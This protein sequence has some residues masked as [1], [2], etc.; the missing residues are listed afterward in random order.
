MRI[1]HV[2]AAGFLTA[3]V[4]FATPPN[5]ASLDG[6]P[7]EYD[8]TDLKGSLAVAG[9]SFGVGNL[10][11]N[12]FV[13]WDSTYLY[14]ALQ[15]YESG[16]K[17]MVLVDVDPGN[18]TGAET[19]TNW[20]TGPTYITFNDAGWST[21]VG[22]TPFGA[23]Y[24]LAS[25][26]FYNSVLRI[27]YTGR[28]I[29]TTGTVER[30]FDV[31]D[32]GNGN[33]PQGT[34]VD[35]VIQSDGSAND[36]KGFEARIPWTNL[37]TAAVTNR[38]GTVNVG[39][40]VPQGATLRFFANLH[41]N[42]A[43]DPYSAS[44]AIPAQTSGNASYLNGRL[45]S[46]NYIDVVVDGDNDGLP[47]VGVGDVNGPYITTAGGPTGKKSAFVQF[48]EPVN[49]DTVTNTLNWLVNGV[50]PTGVVQ[51]AT[52]QVILQLA[53]DLPAAGTLAKVSTTNIQDAAGNS[54]YTY[55]FIDPAAQSIDQAV[56]VRFVLQTASGLGLNPGATNF[57]VNGG[58]FPLSY[59]FPAST[60]S[61]LALDSG[62][63]YYRDVQFPPGTPI[64]INYKYSGELTAGGTNTYEA[65]RLADY[66]TAT[67]YLTLNTNGSSMV[68][69]DYLG[70]AAA[71][72]RPSSTNAGFNALYLDTRRG[73]AGVRERTTM[74]FQLDLRNRN[75]AGVQRVLIQG[76]DPLRGFN[77]SSA[78]IS[79]FAG[80]PAVGYEF[81]G[82][83][84]F[85][86]GTNGDTNSGDGV[87]ART[88]SFTTNGLDDVI[89]PDNPF[90]LVGGDFS[91]SPYFGSAWANRR[92]PKSLIWK[93][94]VLK[95]DGSALESPAPGQPNI[96]YYIEGGSTN[97]TLDPFVW[98][99]D[100]LPLP[101]PSN[102]PTV[103]AISPTGANVRVTFTNQITELQHGVLVSTNLI[104]GWLDYGTRARTSG[105]AGVWIADV[106][107]IGNR[108]EAYSATAGP[109]T[110]FAGVYWEPNILPD[111]GGTARI[112]YTQH[113]RKFAGARDVGLTGSW[114]I[115]P[116]GNAQPMTFMGNGVWY[117]DLVV[118]NTMPTNTVFKPRRLDGTYED[119]GD[120]FLYKGYGRATWT[121]ANPTNEEI[122]TITYDAAGTHLATGLAVNAYIGFD[123]SWNNAGDRPMTNVGGTVWTIA[124]PVPT[125]AVLSVNFVFNN[126]GANPVRIWDSEGSGANSSTGRA[127][128]VFILNP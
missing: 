34:P 67:R 25:E 12:L 60:L 100:G 76:S 18:G 33:T 93:F 36:L 27:T 31:S 103:V 66:A 23:D 122:F 105:V 121:P 57:Y 28:E 61:P 90:N 74:T 111:T 62:T 69:T 127:N 15:G 109:A 96:E 42:T 110:P 120:F 79:D 126:N 38:F 19:T 20:L 89:V 118:S 108:V 22:G 21:A 107:S 47:D 83:E 54:R 44:D 82:V 10:I 9:S 43:S 5:T 86:N 55:A 30:I 68:I 97:I 128:R 91:T 94:Y 6:R 88:W 1:S 52:N 70:A 8:G 2:L 46:D 37:Y 45:V 3:S 102:S 14:V 50:A 29:P 48:S 17:L 59:G 106:P 13:T 7:I 113:S 63:L 4:A 123:E 16:N 73:D 40:V 95:T 119:G 26:G 112:Y 115:P 98:N 72:Y 56:T 53:V 78:N 35:M 87:Y 92:S 124:L 65:V 114:N 41:N 49:T 99:N 24:M 75:L 101:P 39:E 77:N 64:K 51:T 85:D 125:S 116:W 104:Q 32:S 11:T 117:Y 71:P 58:S 80:Q 81:G 84:L